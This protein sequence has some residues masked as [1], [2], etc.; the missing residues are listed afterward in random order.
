M[1]PAFF[2]MMAFMLM[3]KFMLNDVPHALGIIE[4][5]APGWSELVEFIGPSLREAVDSDLMERIVTPTAAAEY[6]TV[7]GGYYL[8]ATGSASDSVVDSVYKI[9]RDEVKADM[10]KTY[11]LY[12]LGRHN[13]HESVRILRREE[14]LPEDR[15]IISMPT[16]VGYLQALERILWLDSFMKDGSRADKVIAIDAAMHMV[17]DEGA[18]IV[19]VLGQGIRGGAIEEIT[20]L[21]LE[22]LFNR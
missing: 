2:D 5:S 3:S 19:V 11:D 9:I 22:E 6:K 1:I 20:P 18:Y 12:P 21:V 4:D 8:I 10:N 13:I 7:M 15:P 16:G 14:G 17:H